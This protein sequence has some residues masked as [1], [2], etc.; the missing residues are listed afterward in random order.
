[1]MLVPLILV[2]LYD[3]KTNILWDYVKLVLLLIIKYQLIANYWV[4]I[5]DKMLSE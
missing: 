5:K 4:L 3:F 2:L 1:M